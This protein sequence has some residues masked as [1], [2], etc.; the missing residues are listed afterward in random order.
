MS[1]SARKIGKLVQGWARGWELFVEA[2]RGPVDHLVGPNPWGGT[3]VRR[4]QGKPKPPAA[5][6]L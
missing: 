1:G 3:T 6:Q 2:T 4:S 5:P